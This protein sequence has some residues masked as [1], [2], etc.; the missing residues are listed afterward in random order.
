MFYGPPVDTCDVCGKEPVSVRRG[1]SPFGQVRLAYCPECLM[2]DVE[3]ATVADEML[4]RGGFEKGKELKKLI[5]WPLLYYNVWH[6]GRS[7]P[8]TEY[9]EKYYTPPAKT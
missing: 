1:K 8:L 2:A 3:P 5:A 9:A 6:D 7:V 4:T